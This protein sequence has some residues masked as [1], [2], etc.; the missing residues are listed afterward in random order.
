MLGCVKLLMYTAVKS[1]EDLWFYHDN[2]GIEVN[3]PGHI[4][5]LNGTQSFCAN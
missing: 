2:H 1:S 4:E 5:L 3:T